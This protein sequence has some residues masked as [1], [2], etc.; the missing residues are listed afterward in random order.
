MAKKPLAE[1]VMVEELAK[2]T[3]KYSGAD[4]GA[5]VNEAVMLAI[6]EY[7]QSGQCKIEGETCDYMVEKKHFDEALKLVQTTA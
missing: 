5:L 7:V 4:L 6:R 2:S 3:D 1:D